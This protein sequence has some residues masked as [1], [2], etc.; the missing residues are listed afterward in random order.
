MKNAFSLIIVL[1]VMALVFCGTVYSV[2][3]PQNKQNESMISLDR[4][5]ELLE[6]IGYVGAQYIGDAPP[7]NIPEC[8]LFDVYYFVLSSKGNDYYIAISKEYDGMYWAFQSENGGWWHMSSGGIAK[9][10]SLLYNLRISRDH[11]LISDG[12][13]HI[14]FANWEHGWTKELSASGPRLTAQTIAHILPAVPYSSDFHI[15]FASP[16]DNNNVEYELYDENFE[17]RYKQTFFT[18]P[19]QSGL[20][21]LVL[22]ASWTDSDGNG[23]RYQFFV[24]F[25][26]SNGET[27]DGSPATGNNSVYIVIIAL[28][29]SIILW[30]IIIEKR[31][32]GAN[33]V[34]R[35]YK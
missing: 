21:Y 7:A 32:I 33:V 24:K 16:P 6:L 11:K 35:L 10:G 27:S 30:K 12:E 1:V 4:A 13:E 19:P 26:K 28:I 14:L 23:E 2:D 8:D 3:E 17:I 22:T 29:A 34:G 5:K 9:D 20:Y 15:E 25:V 31:G 18:P